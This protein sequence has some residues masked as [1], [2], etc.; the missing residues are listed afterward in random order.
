MKYWSLATISAWVTFARGVSS[1]VGFAGASGV[2]AAE[3]GVAAAELGVV[4]AELGGGA[5][6]LGAEPGGAG[7]GAGEEPHP[8]A[9]AQIRAAQ[10]IDMRSGVE[11]MPPFSKRT[12]K[13]GR[14]LIGA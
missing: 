5:S 11:G 7:G 12:R 9:T 13:P 14:R 4:A 6:T 2:A 10:R 1:G 3:L 8:A